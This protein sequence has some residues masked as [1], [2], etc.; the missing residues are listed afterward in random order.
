M[1]LAEFAKFGIPLLPLRFIRTPIKPEP[2]QQVTPLG[3]QALSRSALAANPGSQTRASG[4]AEWEVAVAVPMLEVRERA[5]P[6]NE[7]EIPPEVKAQT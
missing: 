5:E 1:D 3:A 2:L 4:L 7:R 6:N